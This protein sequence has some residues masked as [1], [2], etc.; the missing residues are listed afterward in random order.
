M[1]WVKEIREWDKSI[2]IIVEVWC[3]YKEE[4]EGGIWFVKVFVFEGK[5]FVFV[6]CVWSKLCVCF[7]C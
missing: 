7:E 4:G 1:I 2:G 6:M 5:F 3:V